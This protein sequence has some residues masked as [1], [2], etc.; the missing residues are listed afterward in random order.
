[1]QFSSLLLRADQ[2]KHL[3]F[4][5]SFWL[6][7]QEG[8]YFMYGI[9]SLEMVIGLGFDDSYLGLGITSSQPF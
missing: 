2:T 3:D 6:I 9:H 4:G 5:G 7:H 1:M 8:C